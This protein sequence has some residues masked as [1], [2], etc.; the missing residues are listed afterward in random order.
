MRWLVPVALSASV[1]AGCG[2]GGGKSV[3]SNADGALTNAAFVFVVTPASGDRVSSGFKVS[4]C[5]STF[6]GSLVWHLGAR[7]GHTLA[8]GIA[9]GGGLGA[10]PFTFTVQYSVPAREIGWLLVF[11]P[12]VTEYGFPPPRALIPLVLDEGARTSSGSAS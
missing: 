10:G 6:E 4:G 2:G 8:K 7:D 1:L 9:Q 11:A 3:C 5:S 12:R